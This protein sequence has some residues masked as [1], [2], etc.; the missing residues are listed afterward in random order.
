MDMLD[1]GTKQTHRAANQRRAGPARRRASAPGRASTP[2]SSPLSAC[3][4]N[5]DG[6][7]R[8]LC[9]CDPE[10]RLP[11]SRFQAPAKAAPRRHPAREECD[12]TSMAMRVLPRL[13]YGARPRLRQPVH[14]LRHG[15][16]GGQAH[17]GR[18]ARN[19][20]D[21][22]FKPNNATLV[23]VGDTT[24]AEITPKLEKL[25]RHWD[26]GRR[27]EKEHRPGPTPAKPAVYLID[28]PARSSPS[29]S[30]A[31]SRPPKANPQ[32]IAIETHELCPG[33]HL[34]LPHQ[35]EPARRQALELR[36][37]S[38]SSDARGQRPFIVSPPSKPTKP[39]TPCQEIDKELRGIIGDKPVA[40]DELANNQKNETLGMAGRFETMR[41]VE[42]ALSQILVLRSARGLLRHLSGQGHEPARGGSHAGRPRRGAS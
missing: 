37:T 25:F 31:M 13:L 4:A 40:P 1:E 23:V 8:H 6:V 29:S 34:H 11:R 2:P 24:L 9:R 7:A 16:S 35:H 10:P 14:W 30:P 19:S 17:P 5:L 33:R 27:A 20:I 21:T 41:A 28:R 12:P 42:G 15:S 22:W 38:A 3:K 32:E 26:S 39:R 36:R 18:D